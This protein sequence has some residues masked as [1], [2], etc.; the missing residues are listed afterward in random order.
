VKSL[1]WTV[2]GSTDSL[3]LISN[4]VGW[5]NTKLG[6]ELVT[7]QGCASAN[8]TAQTARST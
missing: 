4:I 6:Q 1:A 8:G 7:E 5:L 2:A 3:R